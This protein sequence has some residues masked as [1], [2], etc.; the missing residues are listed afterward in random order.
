MDSSQK[1]ILVVDDDESNLCLLSDML[2]DLD[3][4]PIVAESGKE[5]LSFASNHTFAMILLDID[6]P[7]EKNWGQNTVFS[8]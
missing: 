5:A 7:E 2:K 8:L 1:R 4:I 3:V 6:M